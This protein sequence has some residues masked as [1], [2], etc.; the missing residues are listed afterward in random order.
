MLLP[1]PSSKPGCN[2][3]TD[4]TCLYR[5]CSNGSRHLNWHRGQFPVSCS[6]LVFWLVRPRSLCCSVLGPTLT[7]KGFLSL[8]RQDTSWIGWL[9]FHA[10]FC[11]MFTAHLQSLKKIMYC[12]SKKV[13]ALILFWWTTWFGVKKEKKCLFRREVILQ[14][15]SHI[16]L[17]L[18][19]FSVIYGFNYFFSFCLLQGYDQEIITKWVPAPFVHPPPLLPLYSVF[20]KGQAR[21]YG[22]FLSLFFLFHVTCHHPTCLKCMFAFID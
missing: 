14:N 10:A 1:L 16:N 19:L 18:C 5:M 11:G 13:L 22:G 6:W 12:G 17:W 20:Y 3:I 21:S 8:W 4:H 2:T 7:F 15:N 9:P